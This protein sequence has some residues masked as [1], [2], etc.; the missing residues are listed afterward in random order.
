MVIR[1]DGSKLSLGLLY[2][3]VVYVKGTILVLWK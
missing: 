1:G 3:T 2:V